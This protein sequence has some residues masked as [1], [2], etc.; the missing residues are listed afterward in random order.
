LGT[1]GTALGVA[2]QVTNLI[3]AGNQLIRIKAFTDF[4]F[5]GASAASLS[6]SI[7]GKT[8]TT[9]GFVAADGTAQGLTTAPTANGNFWVARTGTTLTPTGTNANLSI[10][11]NGVTRAF[12]PTETGLAWPNVPT[13]TS[14][15][16]DSGKAAG[17]TVVKITGTGFSATP[18]DF[19]VSFC[20]I[21]V[22]PSASTLVLLTATS[23]PTSNLALGL[24]LTVYGGVCPVVVT[25][26]VGGL[27]SPIS[28]DSNFTYLVN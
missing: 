15:D 5:N 10:T 23:P 2:N 11:Q 21:D 24:G 7:G 27:K 25:R 19:T 12:T 9:V 6:G 17:G 3:P 16:I 26:I 28:A 18:G 4:A 1:N 13:V 22:T 20:G 14:L 8:L